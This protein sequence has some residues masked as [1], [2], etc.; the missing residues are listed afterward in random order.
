MAEWEETNRDSGADASPSETAVTSYEAEKQAKREDRA[1]ARKLEQAEADI[2]R[3]EAELAGL[4]E[5]MASPEMA[6]N[7]MLL[8]EKQTE[9]ETKRA[10]LDEVYQVWEALMEE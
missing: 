9:A 10:E 5:Q 7:Y 4:E 1:R 3:L 6:T 8:R 2:A